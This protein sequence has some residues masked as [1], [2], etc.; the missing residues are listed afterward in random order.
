MPDPILI[1]F[2]TDTTQLESA[3]N[4]LEK[5][6]LV[7]KDVADSFR[8]TNNEVKAHQ[9]ELELTGK[10]AES[11][12]IDLN[13]MVQAMKG[14]PKKIIEDASKKTLDETGKIIND[15]ANKTER[16]STQLRN[17]KN[18]LSVLSA[19]GKENT[20]EFKAMTAQTIQLQKQIDDTSARVKTLASNTRGLDVALSLASGV[21]GGFA[22]AQGAA[23][24]FGTENEELQRTLLRVQ[25]ALSILN[26]LQAIAAATNRQSAISQAITNFTLKE[27]SVLQTLY[28]FAI[29]RTTA[30]TTAS[31]IAARAFRTALLLTG[32]GAVIV[33]LAAAANAMG[34]FGG[35]TDDA[36]QSI[37]DQ[38][39]AA[40]EL[41]TALR[42]TFEIQQQ[43]RTDK[44]NDLRRE[45]E[46]R[47]AQGE[48]DENI[49]KLEDERI[50][51]EIKKQRTLTE[52]I[53]AG[54]ENQIVLNKSLG[55]TSA[56][57]A[58]INRKSTLDQLDAEQKLKDLINEKYV[59]RA[60][61][62]KKGAD[63]DKK[64]GEDA[65][66]NQK[67]LDERLLK[68]RNDTLRAKAIGTAKFF[69]QEAQNV[70]TAFEEVFN[71]LGVDFSTNYRENVI[72][73]VLKANDDYYAVIDQRYRDY[74]AGLKEGADFEKQIM[75]EKYNT[76][77]AI[78][79]NGFAIINNIQNKALQ[80]EL[81][82]L[83]TQLQSKQISQKKFDQEVAAA[84][85]KNAI[86]N[87][88]LSI[89]EAI[90]SGALSVQRALAQPPGVPYTIP[91][92][93]LAGILAATQIAVIAST[94]I[95]K[96]KAGTKKAPPGWKLV[97]EEG[98]ELINDVGGYQIKTHRESMRMMNAFAKGPHVPLFPD[99]GGMSLAMG[100]GGTGDALNYDKLAHAVTKQIKQLP[101]HSTQITGDGIMNIVK[102][103]NI[104]EKQMDDRYSS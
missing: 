35:A 19:E 84:K 3:V 61:L 37:K 92:G 71:I 46:L 63:D 43:T 21:A 29:G 8:K 95:P 78:V 70:V 83:D 31:T 7:E 77:I 20:D 1:K 40:D 96:F 32:V 74:L 60:I 53:I 18:E 26:G 12:T 68:E 16:L 5:L 75:E 103:G 49:F 9:K 24:L 67:E 44:I 27:G 50:D 58:D 2:V 55:F 81:H 56:Q 54:I 36:T 98:P 59:L 23:A 76:F 51:L 64:A 102:R 89:A 41:N 93:V 73:P 13:D 25:A 34:L 79:S 65:L 17:L 30:V 85:R 104:T 62:T 6:G 69:N 57:I 38:K 28:A 90:I 88:V 94:P 4:E 91:F 97:G 45:I 72:E 11:V 86:Q 101:L 80:D 10:K 22:V 52:T 87:K 39:T 48:T 14:I 15:V 33:L 47:Q 82:S 42:E 100:D 66:K 99:F